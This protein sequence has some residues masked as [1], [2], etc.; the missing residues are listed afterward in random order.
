MTK[1]AITLSITV[2]AGGICL[3][4]T[5]IWLDALIKRT[6]CLCSNL[7]MPQSRGEHAIELASK[8]ACSLAAL[9]QHSACIQSCSAMVSNIWHKSKGDSTHLGNWSPHA[10]LS[11]VTS[12][13]LLLLQL[14]FQCCIS[15][16]NRKSL[17]FVKWFPLLLERPV[18][19]DWRSIPNDWGKVASPQ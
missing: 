19:V 8:S 12:L 14:P 11:R 4:I 16:F 18:E 15:H 13:L 1:T 5:S 7:I 3:L 6:K 9:A 10:F 17:P 2:S